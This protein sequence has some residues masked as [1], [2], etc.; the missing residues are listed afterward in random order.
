MLGV[1][2]YCYW[3]FSFVIRQQGILQR[4]VSF[5]SLQGKCQDYWTI[6]GKGCLSTWFWGP[7][8]NSLVLLLRVCSSSSQQDVWW[9]KAAHFWK[10]TDRNG[11]DHVPLS[12]LRA[13]SM[14]W[15]PLRTL[16]I[17]WEPA[18]YCMGLLG[19]NYSIGV[20]IFHSHKPSVGDLASPLL[21]ITQVFISVIVMGVCHITLVL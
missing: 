17:Y 19:N 8:H 10:V 6:K 5:A 12:L 20:A 7:V 2:T 13:P 11:V 3:E 4:H 16:P 14:T 18:L 21:L 1:P 9:S 15:E